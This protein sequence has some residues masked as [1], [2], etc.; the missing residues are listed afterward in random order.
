VALL[1][2]RDLSAPG[3]RFIPDRPELDQTVIAAEVVAE[4][5]IGGVLTLLPGVFPHELRWIVEEDRAYA[6]AE[7][8]AFLVA[9]LSALS[10][11]V[12]NRPVGGSLCGVAW[13]RERWLALAAMEGV[14]VATSAVASSPEAPYAL[15]SFGE[16]DLRL[17]VVCG[18]V[19]GDAPPG[20]ADFAR[21]LARTAG[22][23]VL[24]AEFSSEN[25]GITF[26]SGHPFPDVCDPQVAAA[27]LAALTAG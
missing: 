21:R 22:M 26:S 17:T 6:A 10:C 27:L 3:W 25:D 23:D 4:R 14:P 12:L 24:V 18:E 13:P 2:P 11:T 16:A 20:E 9:W 8:H 7:I 1:T 5:D 15:R 19:V